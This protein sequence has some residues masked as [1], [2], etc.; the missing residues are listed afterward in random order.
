MNR[1]PSDWQ[2]LEAIWRSE[3]APATP[4]AELRRAVA[5]RGRALGWVTAGEVAMIVGLAAVTGWRLRAGLTPFWAAWL[6]TL[7]LF[8]AAAFGAALWNRRGIWRPAAETTRDLLRLT[9]ER[10]RRR[11]RT[12]RMALDLLAAEGVAVLG[13]LLWAVGGD[14]AR[15]SWTVWPVL[16]VTLAGFAAWALLY[17]RRARR[18]LAATAALRERLEAEPESEDSAL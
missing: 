2:V 3:P 5:R 14:A 6:G 1:E 9:E 4:P 16:G 13:L 11:A 18:E 15:L 12:A 7:W 17:G 8:A 10:A